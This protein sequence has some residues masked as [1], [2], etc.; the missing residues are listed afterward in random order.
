MTVELASGQ[1][2]EAS[3]GVIS[4]TTSRTFHILLFSVRIHHTHFSWGHTFPE[5]PEKRWRIG[6]PVRKFF[7]LEKPFPRLRV[8]LLNV[9]SQCFMFARVLDVG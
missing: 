9:L 1:G 6:H 7:R 4:R 3:I 2:I 8:P 5:K